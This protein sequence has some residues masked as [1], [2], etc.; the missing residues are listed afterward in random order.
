MELFKA[1]DLEVKVND[2]Y[3]LKNLNFEISDNEITVIYSSSN[4]SLKILEALSYRNKPVSGSLFYGNEDLSLFSKSNLEEW[5]IKDVQY[6]SIKDSLFDELSVNENIYLPLV[7]NRI[8]EDNDYM[9]NLLEELDLTDLLDSKVTNIGKLDYYKTLIAR[10]LSLKPFVLL[11]ENIERDFTNVELDVL[12][13]SLTHINNLYKTAIVIST[14]NINLKR[15][16]SR[17]IIIED[18]TIKND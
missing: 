10:A 15:A 4:E 7:L 6:V 3:I 17:T 13:D 14:S 12:L 5:R 11:L 2:R 8:E 1:K 18:G 9:N 16:G